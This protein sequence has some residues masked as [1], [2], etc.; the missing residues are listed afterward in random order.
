MAD[1]KNL[2]IVKDPLFIRCL[3]L[4]ALSKGTT[5]RYGSLLVKDGEVLGQGYNRAIAHPS[6]GRLERILRM[7]YANHAEVEAMDQGLQSLGVDTLEGY[8]IY[9]GGYFPKPMEDFEQPGR[10]FMKKGAVFTCVRCI[11]YFERYNLRNIF[12]PTL[13]GWSSL[14][15]AE[16][17]EI[18][19]EYKYDGKDGTHTKR[20]AAQDGDFTISD[21][22]LIPAEELGSD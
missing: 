17:K 13:N 21:V 2:D 4:A 3:S 5:E 11:P 9:V 1:K 20:C 18:A 8:D 19:E 6:F 14:A 7:G 16:A 10:L 15:V 22:E 12:V